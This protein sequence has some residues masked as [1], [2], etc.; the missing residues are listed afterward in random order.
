MT[1]RTWTH[2]VDGHEINDRVK[3]LTDVPEI[4]NLPDH[5]LLLFPIAGDWPAFIRAQPR[6][7]ILT[8]NVQMM[9]CTW[10]TYQ[11]RLAELSGWLTP[12]VHTYTFQV[13][14]MA[15]PATLYVVFRNRVVDAAS[16]RLTFAAV[17]PKSERS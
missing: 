1:G 14:G 3:Y 4:D 5:D 2:K 16:R 17:V 6:E 7:G 9:P 11:E 8:F 10:E 12:G 15:A 13:R